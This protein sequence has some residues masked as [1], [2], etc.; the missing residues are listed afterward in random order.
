[1]QGE[2]CQLKKDASGQSGEYTRCQTAPRQ[3]RG[4]WLARRSCVNLQY[5]HLEWPPKHT[6][7][8]I[9]IMAEASLPLWTLCP[10]I[11]VIWSVILAFQTPNSV[12]PRGTLKRPLFIDNY[13]I[14]H[15][16][17]TIFPLKTPREAS[18]AQQAK[19]FLFLM[20]TIT[21]VTCLI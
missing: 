5:Y 3:R 19:A 7:C 8:D 18:G 2:M 9:V 12:L 21:V 10:P 15:T 16:G 11:R 6:L 17:T 4:L 14:N 13:T 1:M 20:F